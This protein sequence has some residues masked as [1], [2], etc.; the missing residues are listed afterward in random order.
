VCRALKLFQRRPGR[1]EV[2]IQ[3]L[4]KFVEPEGVPLSTT[5]VPQYRDIA[6]RRYH[7]IK[8]SQCGGISVTVQYLDNITAQLQAAH[9]SFHTIFH[10]KTSGAAHSFRV[11]KLNVYM[12]FFNRFYSFETECMHTLYSFIELRTQCVRTFYMDF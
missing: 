4:S 1:C 10:S 11:N 12:T 7:N 8:I 2:V 9:T 5:V 3:K 6:T